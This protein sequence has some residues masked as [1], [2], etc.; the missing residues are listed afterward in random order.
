MD[1]WFLKYPGD[2]HRGHQT[3]NNNNYLPSDRIVFTATHPDNP[4][5]TCSLISEEDE[6]GG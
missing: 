6:L 1:S 4:K 5:I 3:C 2:F